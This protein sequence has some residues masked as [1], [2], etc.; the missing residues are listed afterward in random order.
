MIDIAIIGG[1][2]A[3]LWTLNRLCALG[4]DAHLF[5]KTALGSGQTIASQGIIHGGIKYALTGGLTFSKPPDS[6]LLPMPERWTNC[7]RGEGEIDLRSVTVL[8]RKHEIRLQNRLVDIPLW[9]FPEPVLDVKSLIAALAAP[10]WDFIHLGPPPPARLTI[11]TAGRGN[12]EAARATQRRP[13][14][15]F[16]V[17]PN[18]F[19]TPVYLHWVGRNKKPLMTVTT[20]YLNEEE[21][22]YLGGNVAEKAVGMTDAEA[23]LWARSE[24]QY[25]FP[26]IPWHR[27]QW[28]IHDVD[29]AEPA[30]D[31][32]LPS[33]PVIEA[34]GNVAVAWPAKLALAP[35]LADRLVEWV[36]AYGPAT[37]PATALETP[38]PS[39]APYP[40]ETAKWL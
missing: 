39:I 38:R 10:H 4:Y 33:E 37:C 35:V 31:G 27:K 26:G 24:I 36:R 7:L 1:G 34:N 29:R 20:H 23:L 21:V 5:E 18:P 11:W 22:L 19:G 32:N 17:K 13:L 40:W 30:N 25:R 2:V 16:M 14:R 8:S 12:E 6:P 9:V 15:M 28:A 3:G